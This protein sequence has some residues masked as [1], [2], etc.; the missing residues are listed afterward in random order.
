[1]ADEA[2]GEHTSLY[3]GD[4]THAL[5]RFE[6]ADAL[7]PDAAALVRS[8]QKAGKVVVILS[9]DAARVARRVGETLRVSHVVAEQLPEQK[10][11]FVRELQ[12]RGAVLAMVGD[13]IND[14]AVMRAADVS[15][16]MGGGAALA[17]LHADCVLASNRLAS[18]GECADI[19]ARTLRIVRQNLAWAT[20]YNAVA[21]PAAA[22]GLLS[23]WVSA[24]GMS[25]SSALVVLN[26]LRLLRAS[27]APM[28]E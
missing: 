27:H 1:V 7:R 11:Q 12:A 19:A 26:A 16:A 4:G 6:V 3:L 8:L 22:F 23:P 15:F 25:A 9:G 20:L 5:A 24:A 10:L 2:E 28:E 17:Q 18:L 13:G 14:A 21:I